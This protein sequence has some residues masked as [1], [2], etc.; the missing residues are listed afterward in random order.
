MKIRIN[1]SGDE[2]FDADTLIDW[3]NDQLD[4]ENMHGGSSMVAELV[5]ETE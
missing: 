5:E 3:I 4:I 1:I 2:D